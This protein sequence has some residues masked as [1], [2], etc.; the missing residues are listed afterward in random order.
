[1]KELSVLLNATARECFA[2]AALLVILGII[3]KAM[4]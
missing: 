2:A 1:M 3:K 4:E